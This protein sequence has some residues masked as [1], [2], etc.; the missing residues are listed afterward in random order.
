MRNI[1]V[2]THSA[3]ID[4]VGAASLIKIKYN[5]PSSRLFFSGYNKEDILFAEKKMRKFYGKDFTLF[6]TDL[7]LNDP[8]IEVWRAIVKKVKAKGGKVYWFDHHPWSKKAIARVAKECEVAIVGENEKYCATEITRI[9]LGLDTPFINEFV[10]VVHFSDFN[11]KPRDARSRN[12]I[13][14]YALSITS[15]TKSKSGDSIQRSLRHYTDVI[16]GRRFTDEKILSESRKFEKLN[17]DRIKKMLKEIYLVG[18][19]IAIGFAAGVQSTQGCGAIINA[20]G[21][22][23]GIVIDPNAGKG[24]FRSITSDISGMAAQLGGGGHPHA[25]GFEIDVK[26][27]P[28]K[29][30][31]DRENFVKRIQKIGS[32]L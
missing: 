30:K 19:K 17:N 1:A 32:T 12:L 16:S 9:E 26:K 28:L 8:V 11:L 2:L 14:A 5:L 18:S 27:H 22:D 3:D 29:T 23:V 7:S 15:F 31:V 6:I 4:G 25:S 10:R 20:T 21:R 13:K 24:S